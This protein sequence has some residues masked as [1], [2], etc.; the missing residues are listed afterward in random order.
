MNL[1]IKKIEQLVQNQ[2]ILLLM[3]VNVQYWISVFD[4]FIYFYV[5]IFV[6]NF[7]WVWYFILN[8]LFTSFL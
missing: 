3:N 1:K 6:T 5:L 8:F 2:N 4:N 7:M